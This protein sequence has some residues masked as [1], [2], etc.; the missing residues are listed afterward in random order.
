MTSIDALL[1]RADRLNAIYRHL[2]ES[3]WRLQELE[4]AVAQYYVLVAL[5]T[6]GM[7]IEAGHALERTVDGNTFG[8]TIALLRKAAKIPAEL[9]QRLPA[10]LQD[11]N[12]LV[13]GSLRTE[14][15]AIYD[16]SR[17]E[18]LLARLVSIADEA[19]AILKLLGT[20]AEKFVVNAGVSK[21]EV[22]SLTEQLLSVWRGDDAA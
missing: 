17:C 13:H 8:R 6:R 2:G 21:Q 14:R 11:R 19:A 4:G 10:L 22:D 16:E 5:A 12:W 3:L 7:G 20:A 15:S 1:Q 18:A 9:E